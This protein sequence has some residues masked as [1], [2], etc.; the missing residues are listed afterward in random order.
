M[1]INREKFKKW[2]INGGKK[3]RILDFFEE[4]KDEA[5]TKKEICNELEIH[6]DDINTSLTLLKRIGK[7]DN[8]PPYWI[9]NKNEVIK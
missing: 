7:I 5:F 8:K 3:N 9:L 2:I 6:P 1:P 4:N